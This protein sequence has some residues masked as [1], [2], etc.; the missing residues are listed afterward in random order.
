[1][2][3]LLK[4]LAILLFFKLTVKL[5]HAMLQTWAYLL[6]SVAAIFLLPIMAAMSTKVEQS[7][8]GDGPG[9]SASGST[10]VN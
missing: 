4:I 7:A 10:A 5:S 2:A 9:K 3:L 6:S 1:M 8:L